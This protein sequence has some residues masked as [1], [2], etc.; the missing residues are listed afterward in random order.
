MTA[1]FRRRVGAMLE[2]EALLL[3][4]SMRFL[5]AIATGS[6]FASLPELLSLDSSD[7]P[8]PIVSGLLL[9]LPLLLLSNSSLPCFSGRLG[10]PVLIC[11]TKIPPTMR[12]AERYWKG[13]GC[14]R[15]CNAISTAPE[16]VYIPFSTMEIKA[17]LTPADHA[18]A[19]VP[20]T[21]PSPLI[22]PQT[23][24]TGMRRTHCSSVNVSLIKDRSVDAK[25]MSGAMS[26][27]QARATHTCS[28]AAPQLIAH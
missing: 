21:P 18:K 2:S 11:A 25:S 16:M 22:R 7:S 23:M 17:E 15:N 8:L 9:S 4:L 6:A 14:S 27:A 3:R 1:R 20:S 10:R 13:E 28:V 5:P 26:V 19:I 24:I 12:A